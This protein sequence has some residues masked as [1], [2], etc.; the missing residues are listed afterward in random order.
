MIGL[1]IW[2]CGA[3]DHESASHGSDRQAARA[4][5]NVR[6]RPAVD[7]SSLLTP[8]DVEIVEA[9]MVPDELVPGYRLIDV[10]GHGALGVVYLAHQDR[11]QRDVAI[12]AILQKRLSQTNVCNGFRRRRPRSDDLQHP[13]IVA[14]FDS[15]THRGRLFLVMELVRGTDLRQRIDQGPIPLDHALSI[16][17]QTAAGLPTRLHLNRSFI[18]TSSRPT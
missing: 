18:A 2:R 3:T 14:A 5:R 1:S 8:T 15:G 16:L 6:A 9:F 7:E 13:N 12:K 11:M 17:R 4:I 10:L